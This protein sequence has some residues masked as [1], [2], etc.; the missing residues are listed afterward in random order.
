MPTVI[1]HRSVKD[2][3]H[4]LA[5]PRRKEFLR[6]SVSPATACS[7]T[8]GPRPGGRSLRTSPTSTPLTAASA[9]QEAA[10]AMEYAGVLANTAMFLVERSHSAPARKGAPFP[11]RAH[12]ARR[13]IRPRQRVMTI[14]TRQPALARAAK[15]ERPAVAA[16]AQRRSPP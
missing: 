5:S 7:S 8:A 6:P 12:H 2:T 10:D 14:L 11:G 9:A 16:P 3:G 4:W 1:A 15:R 13:R